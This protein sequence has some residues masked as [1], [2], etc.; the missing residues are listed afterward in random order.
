MDQVMTALNKWDQFRE[1]LD[2]EIDGVV[3][4]INNHDLAQSLGVVGKA[5]RG[6]IAYKFPAQVVTT[7]LLEIKVNVGRTGVLTPYAVL[8]PVEIGGVTVKQATLHNF[9]FIAEKD[10]RAGDRVMV[11]RAGEVIPYVMGPVL[12]QRTGQEQ[13]YLPPSICPVCEEEVEHLEGEVAWYCVNNSCEAQLIRNI[14]HFVSRPAMDIVGLGIR[15]VNQLTQEGLINKVS[16]LYKIRKEQLLELEGFGEKKALNLLEAI[17]QSRT[18]SLERLI[19]ALGIRGVGEVVAS[20]LA[21]EFHDLTA[22]ASASQIDLEDLPGI[23]PNIAQAVVDWFGRP[24]NQQVLQELKAAGVWPKISDQEGEVTRDLPLLEKSFVLT[25]KLTEYSRAEA[26]K[27]IQNLGGRVVS[28][29]SAKTNYLIVGE[30]P[31]S[32]YQK[33]QDLGINILSENEF[34]Q[35]I[36]GWLSEGE[37][38]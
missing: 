21:K 4:K 28:S 27:I 8:E 5:P 36:S 16:D 31:G 26:K 13:S 15:I 19:T 35:M 20:A 2:F 37:G 12:E 9:D 29:V 25:G 33:A 14:E 38:D 7:N 24:S 10:I 23:G 1:D 17:D 32:K 22:L 11:K 18:Q 3:V 34:S 6:A 30:D